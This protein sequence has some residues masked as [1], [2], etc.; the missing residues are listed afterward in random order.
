MEHVIAAKA[1]AFG[2]AL[3]PSFI[4]YQKQVVVHAQAMAAAFVAKGYKLIS[5]RFLENVRLRNT[6]VHIRKKCSLN[7][8]FEHC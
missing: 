5:G 3:E 7:S 4:D 6:S 2:E 1:I 8:L